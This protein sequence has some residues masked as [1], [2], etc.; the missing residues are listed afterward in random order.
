[1]SCYVWNIFP[2]VDRQYA[3]YMARFHL[4]IPTIH[5]ANSMRA[6]VLPSP[7]LLIYVANQ[8]LQPLISLVKEGI[9]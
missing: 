3:I 2:K 7:L 5:L 1:M 4:R 6:H 8:I 9:P